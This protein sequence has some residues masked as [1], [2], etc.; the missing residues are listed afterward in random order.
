MPAWDPMSVYA[1]NLTQ[2]LAL[3]RAAVAAAQQQ[4]QQQE[5]WLYQLTQHNKLINLALLT[6]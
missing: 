6:K 2:T 3:Q 5:P 4:Q 1:Q